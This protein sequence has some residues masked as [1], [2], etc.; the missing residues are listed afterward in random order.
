MVKTITKSA[1]GAYN[2]R[3]SNDKIV[4][5][6]KKIDDKYKSK[7]RFSD[8]KRTNTSFS[9]CDMV[10]SV[11]IELP[12][13]NDPSK[14][15]SHTLVIGEMQTFTYSVHMDKYP[16]RSLGNVNAKAF[17]EGPRTIA[18]TLI[19]SVFDRHFY[20][21]ILSL[22]EST[23]NYV[24]SKHSLM[25]ELP[26]FDI[27]ISFTNEY[28]SKAHLT[29]YGISIIDEGQVM[30]MNDIYT[31]NTYQY[32]ANDIEYMTTEDVVYRDSEK[33]YNLIG[34]NNTK[35]KASSYKPVASSLHSSDKEG[36][37]DADV[38]EDKKNNSVSAK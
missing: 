4:T 26:P 37:E 1:D 16:V 19:F 27:T 8:F 7:N 33:T 25:D 34:V 10:A 28:G 35:T 36:A 24:D 21:R 38:S 12:S 31:E 17:T 9:G 14:V 13:K 11:H 29:V 6:Q 3:V 20:Q 23:G 2:K 30:S 5:F 18:G 32:M 22:A 15:S